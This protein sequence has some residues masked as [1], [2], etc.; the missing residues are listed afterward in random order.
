MILYRKN[1]W[2]MIKNKFFTETE[3]IY[4]CHIVKW[5]H[6]MYGATNNITFCVRI[7]MHA[8]HLHFGP[9]QVL[10]Y[11]LNFRKNV[12]D[13]IFDGRLFHM[14]GLRELKLWIPNLLAVMHLTMMSFFLTFVFSLSVNIF[15]MQGGLISF[16]F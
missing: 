4:W 14:F 1:K 12:S 9:S 3:K 11:S 16:R 5:T 7:F 13:F 10:I 6:C 2:K 15:F 8:L